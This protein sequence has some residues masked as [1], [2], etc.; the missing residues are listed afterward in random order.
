[1]PTASPPPPPLACRPQAWRMC[2]GWREWGQLHS[3]LHSPHTAAPMPLAALAGH[4]EHLGI[5][6]EVVTLPPG[7][8]VFSKQ[9]PKA[10]PV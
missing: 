8:A 2:G 9:M 3:S 10:C 4:V 1:M 7:L 6:L 5:S